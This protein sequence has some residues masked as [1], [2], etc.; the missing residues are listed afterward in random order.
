MITVHGLA[1]P[2]AKR[3]T[4]ETPSAVAKLGERTT[5]ADG[6][7]L[8]PLRRIVRH[9]GGRLAIAHGG[10]YS[11]LSRFAPYL[12]ALVLIA[13][14][15]TA[16]PVQPADLTGQPPTS[17]CVTWPDH[18]TVL[19]DSARVSGD[20]LF[21]IINGRL[22]RLPLAE[23]TALRVR[24]PADVRTPLVFAS[25][26]GAILLAGHFALERAPPPVGPC[27]ALCAKGRAAWPSCQCL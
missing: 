12:V 15:T 8:V 11:S 2:F 20:T 25:F 1:W 19:L 5:D 14:C 3:V 27:V 7:R 10:T 17:V 21:G 22:Q 4:R 6:A 13:A 16:R 23:A 18:S 9:D 26:T 24:E